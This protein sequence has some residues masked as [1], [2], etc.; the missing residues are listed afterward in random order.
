VLLLHLAQRL[1]ELQHAPLNHSRQ[2]AAHHTTS[3]TT[4]AAA[5][6]S[7]RPSSLQRSHCLQQLRRY[8]VDCRHRLQR[9]AVRLE[10]VQQQPAQ[11]L[12]A[13]SCKNCLGVF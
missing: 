2:L 11:D 5:A 1:D 8:Y 10:A 7:T 9:L 12:Q 4:R 6:L 13:A 3:A